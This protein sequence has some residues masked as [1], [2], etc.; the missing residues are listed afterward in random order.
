MPPVKISTFRNETICTGR[1]Q[2]INLINNLRRQKH[3]VR[4]RLAAVGII[5]ALAAILVQQRTGN[6]R[7]IDFLGI[8]IEQ[9]MQAA[10]TTPIAQAFPFLS[11]EFFKRFGLP[12][13]FLIHGAAY[14]AFAAKVRSGFA[15][16]SV[17]KSPPFAIETKAMLRYI[18]RIILMIVSVLR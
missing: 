1:R 5:A 8:V 17:G 16:N 11:V 7:P 4:H 14:R 12:E 18:T 15:L 9:F 13:R 6:R 3:A 10:L 2:P